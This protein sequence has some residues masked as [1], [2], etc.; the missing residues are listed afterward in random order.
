M[1]EKCNDVA[2]YH[3]RLNRQNTALK[4][5]G[6]RGVSPHH[7]LRSIEITASEWISSY[8]D[9]ELTDEQLELKL[10]TVI[11]S[12]KRAFDGRLP[13][14]FFISTDPKGY[15]L[16]ISSILMKDNTQPCA[17]LEHDV[18]GFGILAPELD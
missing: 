5:M 4:A 2:S 3:T 8:A 14:G 15:A 12:V 10:D 11:F 13:D 6:A 18:L 16:K 1:C 9:G 17:T 7:I